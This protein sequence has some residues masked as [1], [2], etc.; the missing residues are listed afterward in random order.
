MSLGSRLMQLRTL[1]VG[2][3]SC[4]CA[5][6]ACPDTGEAAVIDPGGNG[7]E[8]LSAIKDMDVR[9]RYLLHTHGHFDHIMATGDVAAATGA[10]ILLH[11]KDRPIYEGLPRQAHI[12]GFVAAKPPAVSQWLQDGQVISLGTVTIQVLHTPGHTPGSVSFYFGPDAALVFAGD[13]LFAHSV[14]RTD[15]P[16]GCFD[17]LA[18]SIRTKLYTL[19]AATRVIPGHGRETLIG[20]ELQHNPYVTAL[21]AH[22]SP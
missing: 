3:I 10:S 2:P 20:H 7:D 17:D 13:T 21:P 9:V 6:V 16:G 15:L 12:F 4:N 14:G 11:E 22:P 1:V 19:P 8:I 18:A 5:I